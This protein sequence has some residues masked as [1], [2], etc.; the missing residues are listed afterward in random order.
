[1]MGNRKVFNCIHC[2][3]LMMGK[4]KVFDVY[5]LCATSDWQASCHCIEE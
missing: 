1:M 4:R 2:A 5:I 3:F